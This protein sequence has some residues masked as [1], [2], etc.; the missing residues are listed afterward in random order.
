MPAFDR[1]QGLVAVHFVGRR[2]IDGIDIRI[3]D[4]IGDIRHRFG[5]TILSR[6][7]VAALCV[8]AHDGDDVAAGGA[9]GADH[10]F[11]G[12]RAC[13]DQAPFYTAICHDT[14]LLAVVSSPAP[15]L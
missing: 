4:E 14:A 10:P 8:P 5:N 2:D 9:N 11:T 3:V 12:D 13:A 15:E 7:G 6:I 1:R